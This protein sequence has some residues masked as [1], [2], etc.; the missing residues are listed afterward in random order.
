MRNVVVVGKLLRVEGFA[1]GGRT[2]HEHL[3]GVE[4]TELIKLNVEL[5][6]VDAL[7]SLQAG[8]TAPHII[9]VIAVPGPAALSFAVKTGSLSSAARRERRACDI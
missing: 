6:H 5:L 8:L 2:S 7:S 1:G 4:A 3:D 9:G